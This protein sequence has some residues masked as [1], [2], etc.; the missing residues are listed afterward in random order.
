MRLASCVFAAACLIGVGSAAA[1]EYV[2]DFE[3][4]VSGSNPS[5]GTA[6]PDNW[7]ANEGVTIT[8]TASIVSG[9]GSSPDLRAWENWSG[10]LN[11]DVAYTG[12]TGSTSATSFSGSIVIDA[13][14]NFF[15]VLDSFQIG[16]F[17][18]TTN[19]V[20]NLGVNNNVVNA[21]TASTN[22]FTG[23]ANASFSS[24]GV[25]FSP[26]I[27]STDGGT[28][29]LHWTSNFNVAVDNIGY[30]VTAV[31][32]PASLG[33]LGLAGIGLIARRRRHA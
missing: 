25:T 5:G 26:A 21:W 31:P 33:L 6:L 30:T 8:Y 3:T 14:A 24:G 16:S 17:T 10:T 13:P 22:G 11:T 7:D 15:V 12:A 9:P 28:V 20:T 18:S 19:A 1:Q 27:S 2:I 29:T 32:E 23:G 4:L